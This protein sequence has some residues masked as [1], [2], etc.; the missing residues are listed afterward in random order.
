MINKK[1][2]L[3]FVGPLASGK[4]TSA[5]YLKDK[6]QGEIFKFSTVLRDILDRLYLKQNRQNL[7]TL[8]TV[9]RQNFSQDI[10]SK[11]IFEDVNNS[12][13]NLIIIDG[14]RR[15]EDIKYL[16]NL[17]NFIL[18]SIDADLKIRYQ[19]LI[20]RNENSDDKNKTLEQF[21]L[22]NQQEPEQKIKIIAEKA[23]EKINNN[24]SFTD[25]YQQLDLIVKKYGY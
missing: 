23:Q 18:I 17:P 4:G 20:K 9:L 2:I 6:Y 22:D 19:R 3:G 21:K 5:Q 14:I 16:K 24:G 7:Q 1:I 12:Q 11:V 13:N 25:L 10:L 15:E 8:S